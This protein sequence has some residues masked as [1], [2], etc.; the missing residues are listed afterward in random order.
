MTAM[1]RSA[2]VGSLILALAAPLD[3]QTVNVGGAMLF[4]S[5]S[6]GSGFS[7][8]DVSELTIP[9][10]AS[11]PLGTRGEL[12]VSTAVTRLALESADPAQP[13]QEMSGVVDSE[14]RL[15]LDVIPDRLVFITTGAL[16]TGM[17]S[18]EV[19]EL[20]ALNVISTDLIG[21]STTTLGTG[22]SVG[23]GFAG[24]IPVGELAI[25]L[26]GTYTQSGSF[27]PVASAP[28]ELKPGGEIRLRA[29]IEGAVAPRSYLRVAGIFA[30]RQKDQIDGTDTNGIGNRFAGYVSLEQGVG[31][32]SL[33]LYVFDM[34]RA[35]PQ[36]EATA[37][38]ASF[39]PKGNLL[40]VGA[41]LTVPVTS[42]A[43]VTPRIEFRNS[44]RAPSLEE[45]SI[46]KLGNSFRFGADLRHNV[47]RNFA[48]V[49]EANGLVGS[50]EQDAE[51][52]DLNGYRF[53]MHVEVRP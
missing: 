52:I 41:Q 35:D 16:P 17:N 13:D 39:V 8:S 18:L 19:P 43:R 7:F 28:E 21:F 29:G 37:L 3:G 25:G 34:Y 45:G 12:A 48:L 2:L 42:S 50:V 15:T 49:I 6:F 23:A 24:A 36:I 31:A 51:S 26:A 46:E 47:N 22:G 10:T 1:N 33:S 27:E 32:S 5:Y 44:G 14:V 53:G 9:L 11:F 4:E 38:G 40:A 30:R 20:A